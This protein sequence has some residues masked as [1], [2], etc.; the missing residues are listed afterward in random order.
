MKRRLQIVATLIFFAFLAGGFVTLYQLRIGRGDDFPPYSSRR[1]DPLGVRALRDSLAEIPG[2]QASTSLAPLSR[3]APMPRRTLVMAG[4]NP[5]QWTMF[6]AAEFSALDAA[7]RAGCR[8]VIAFD[9]PATDESGANAVPPKVPRTAEVKSIKAKASPRAGPP[10]RIVR[11]AGKSTTP[12]VDL[13][14]W[15]GVE[16]HEQRFVGQ[17]RRSSESPSS[18]PALMPWA[19]SLFFKPAPGVGWRP[20]YGIV[21]PTVMERPLGQGSI[22]LASDAYFLTNV[23]LQ[24]ERATQLLVMVCGQLP[25]VEFIEA[26]LGVT[27]QPGVAV[28]ARR[29]GLVPAFLTL[30][31]LAALFAWSRLATF[32]PPLRSPRTVTLDYHPAA[33]LEALLRRSVGGSDLLQLCAAEWRTTARAA[34]AEKIAA[35]M[36]APAPA[37][38]LVGRYNAMVRALRRR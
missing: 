20:I 26:H 21:D 38:G 12:W 34:E 36:A 6:S 11:D 2:L 31:V 25:R 28:L 23:A 14:K 15:W 32:A 29:Y 1:A 18:L 33:G 10:P 24:R 9:S 4:M 22:V 27:E 7:V 19:T 35:E 17:V 37:A 5:D 8:L 13:G 3:I 16:L 30:F